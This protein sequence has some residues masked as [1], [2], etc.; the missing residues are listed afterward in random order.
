MV[1]SNPH[2]GLGVIGFTDR[3]Y[4]L[5]EAGR[6]PWHIPFTVDGR[7]IIALWAHVSDKELKYVRVTHEIVDR[8]A[9]FPASAP[10]LLMGDF[11]SNTVRDREHPGRNRSMLVDKLQGLGLQGVYHQAEHAAHGAETMPL[12]LDVGPAREQPAL[13]SLNA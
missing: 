5:R 7:N 11:N 3:S 4:G 2:K 13:Q 1:G 12:I 6:L 8:H 10:S 9:D